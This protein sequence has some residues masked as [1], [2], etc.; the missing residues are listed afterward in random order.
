MATVPVNPQQEEQKQLNAL[1]KEHCRFPVRAND[2]NIYWYNNGTYYKNFFTEDNNEKAKA[3]AHNCIVDQNQIRNLYLN[4]PSFRKNIIALLIFILTYL[5]RTA[6]R[7]LSYNNLQTEFASSIVAPN[8]WHWFT[9][10][11]TKAMGWAQLGATELFDD[12]LFDIMFGILQQAKSNNFFHIDTFKA[13]LHENMLLS[14]GKTIGVVNLETYKFTSLQTTNN[15]SIIENFNT[16][17]HVSYTTKQQWLSFLTQDLNNE[18]ADNNWAICVWYYYQCVFYGA[19]VNNW[20]TNTYVDSGNYMYTFNKLKF[21]AMHG[22]SMPSFLKQHNDGYILEADANILRV[23]EMTNNKTKTTTNAAATAAPA[24]AATSNA[25]NLLT[26][27]ESMFKLPII[28][29]FN[30]MRKGAW[31][32]IDGQLF[33]DFIGIVPLNSKEA[34]VSMCINK[35]DDYNNNKYFKKHDRLTFKHYLTLA[36]IKQFVNMDE[37]SPSDDNSINFDGVKRLHNC[38]RKVTSRFSN[39]LTSMYYQFMIKLIIYNQTIQTLQNNKQTNTFDDIHL[40]ILSANQRMKTTQLQTPF[41]IVDGNKNVYWCS[42]TNGTIYSVN[43]YG[44]IQNS[45]NTYGDYTQLSNTDITNYLTKLHNM[46]AQQESSLQ[47][48]LY[49]VVAHGYNYQFDAK[50]NGNSSDKDM[51]KVND[52][53]T[54]NTIDKILP[55]STSTTLYEAFNSENPEPKTVEMLPHSN[56]QILINTTK[57]LKSDIVKV[58]IT[59]SLDFLM[60]VYLQ[61]NADSAA[62]TAGMITQKMADESDINMSDCYLITKLLTNQDWF[63]VPE[64]ALNTSPPIEQSSVEQSSV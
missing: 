27:L 64:P 14:N 46:T 8:N 38:I 11:V 22:D 25:N 4:N 56:S 57:L 40:A 61:N 52:V 45:E 28:I 20:R 54:P 21:G 19:T 26:W 63:N 2:T 55:P 34:Y 48:M 17:N 7:H 10:S 12:E 51:I 33:G 41:P 3:S 42:R 36:Y 47:L 16:F 29:E 58:Q 53:S 60:G 15:D 5:Q 43:N 18:T 1:I 32:N 44:A 59:N 13:F 35:H 30:N 6:L 37:T 9:N 62:S 50:F 39:S 49:F 24:T 31:I 23:Y